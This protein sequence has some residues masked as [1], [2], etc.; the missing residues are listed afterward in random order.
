MK[1]VNNPEFIPRSF[2]EPVRNFAPT[3]PISLASAAIGPE[4]VQGKGFFDMHEETPAKKNY[5]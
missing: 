5:E 1:A 3:S 4:F 2:Q